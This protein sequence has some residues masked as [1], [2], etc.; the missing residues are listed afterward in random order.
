MTFENNKTTRYGALLPGLT[1]NYLFRSLFIHKTI[2]QELRNLPKAIFRTSKEKD[3]QYRQSLK[4][5]TKN[6]LE[7]ENYKLNYKEDTVQ[8]HHPDQILRRGFAIVSLNGKM[9]KSAKTLKKSDNIETKFS[10]GRIES[11]V[12]KVRF[13]N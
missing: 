10:D 9:I 1:R 8:M 7:K 12:E 2:T 4:K 11:M 5:L 3:K 13:S 6:S